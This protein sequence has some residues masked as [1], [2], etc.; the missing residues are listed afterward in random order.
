MKILLLSCNEMAVINA[1]GVKI[2]L[3]RHTDFDL[4]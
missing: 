3:T 4:D 1:S 2:W